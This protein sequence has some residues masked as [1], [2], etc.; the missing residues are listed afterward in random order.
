MLVR[1]QG[2][3]FGEAQKFA[4]ELLKDI[5]VLQ[6]L[7]VLG[8]NGRVPDRIVWRE[9]DKPAKQKIIIELFHQLAFG[10]NTIKNLKEQRAQQ[11]LRR[12]RRTTL[13]GIEP[14]QAAVQL[15]Q[16]LAHYLTDRAQRVICRNAPFRH[17]VREH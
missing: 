1:Q 3:Y 6:T 4:H 9:A 12:D 10:A 16:D 17:N 8:E 7:P 11:L 15:M 14:A 13:A 2:L 5:T